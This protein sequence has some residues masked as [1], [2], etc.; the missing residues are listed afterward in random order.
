MSKPQLSP[1]PR[2]FSSG[3]I[4]VRMSIYTSILSLNKTKLV[5]ITLSINLFILPHM[6][7]SSPPTKG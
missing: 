5:F 3:D 4:V 6:Y 7:V 1:F 2:S